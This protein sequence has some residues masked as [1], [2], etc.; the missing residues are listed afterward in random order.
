M[1]P[2]EKAIPCEPQSFKDMIPHVFPRFLFS[3]ARV[4]P[5]SSSKQIWVKTYGEG[6]LS[7]P[8][9]KC[10]RQAQRP[11]TKHDIKKKGGVTTYR[12]HGRIF[13]KSLSPA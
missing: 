12:A 8:V 4:T 5:A 6:W 3:R 10:P 13:A 1:V 2:L 7:G 11:H 9:K